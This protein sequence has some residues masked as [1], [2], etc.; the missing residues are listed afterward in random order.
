MPLLL[1]WPQPTWVVDMASREVVAVG[2]PTEII[3]P[4][5][6]EE[7]RSDH[8]K[9]EAKSEEP[10]GLGWTGGEGRTP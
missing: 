1:R 5:S 6:D 10:E 2:S 9:D 8:G 7:L 4:E 3:G